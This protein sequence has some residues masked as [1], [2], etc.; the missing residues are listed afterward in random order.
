MRGQ[1]RRHDDAAGATGEVA[2]LLHA[3]LLLGPYVVGAIADFE[4]LAPE[5]RQPPQGLA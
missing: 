2:A 4:L 3:D 5:Q 1:N